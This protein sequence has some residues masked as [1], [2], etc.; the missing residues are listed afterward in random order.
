MRKVLLISLILLSAAAAK[1][2]A[3][4]TSPSHGFWNQQSFSGH[5]RLSG[6][7]RYQSSDFKGLEE[8][9]QSLWF[10]GGIRL[11]SNT[12]LW[13]PDLITLNL[14]A[15]YNPET[16]DEKYLQ[17][18]DRAEVRNITNLDLRATIFNNK[19]VTINAFASLNQSY[20]NREYLTNIKSDNSQWGGMISFN[21]KIVPL[22]VTYRNLKWKQQ[23]METGRI[24]SMDQGDV[25]AR[26]S[27]SFSQRDRNELTWTHNNYLYTYAA[28]DKVKNSTDRVSLTSNINLD[29]EKRYSLNSYVSLYDQQGSN[30]FRKNDVIERLNF[31]ILKNLRFTGDYSLYMMEDDFQSMTR[32]RIYGSLNHQLYES[33]STGLFVDYSDIS[34]TVYDETNL[35]TGIDVNYTKK[36]LSGGRLNIGYRYYRH[37]FDN[38]GAPSTVR[39]TNEEQILS[40]TRITLLNRPYIESGSVTVKDITGTIIYQE[41]PDYTIF[42]RDNFLELQRVP[43]GLI[44]NGQTVIVDYTATQPGAYSYDA[45]NHSVSASILLFERLIEVYYRGSFQDYV[46]LSGADFLTLNYF[47]HNIYGGKIDLGFVNAGIEYDHY[48]SNIIPYSGLRYYLALNSRIG[49]RLLLSANGNVFDY[50]ILDD[51]ADQQYINIS[52]K[53]AYNISQRSKATLE[54]GYLSQA[55]RNID[56]DLLTARAEVTTVIRQLTFKLGANAYNRHYMNSHF[57]FYGTYVEII[58]KF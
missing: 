36:I 3:Q 27:K 55:G 5:V 16:R 22:T 13:D 45:N 46:N 40:D 8:K 54:A 17:I 6:L 28:E 31:Q 53:L 1:T 10:Q 43:G 34:Q 9:Q 58:R 50:K 38:K 32:N 23:E 15:E 26:I 7:Y 19:P 49:S 24:F 20:F 2:G 57:I 30:N 52:G 29:R 39:V 35:K 56:L 33:L 37:N 47:T 25:E 18:P 12:F 21:N 14:S 51:E 48:S 44:A 41:G 42:R 4:N 11:N